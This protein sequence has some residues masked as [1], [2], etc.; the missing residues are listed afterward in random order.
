MVFSHM[1]S[2]LKQT[3]IQKNMLQG[4]LTTLPVL[5]GPPS[6]GRTLSDTK[7]P[8]YVHTDEIR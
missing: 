4:L 2:L 6:R 8:H 1:E 7:K 5:Y 3:E